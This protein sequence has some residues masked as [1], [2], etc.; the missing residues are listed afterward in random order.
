MAKFVR[1]AA[2]VGALSLAA[3]EIHQVHQA[4]AACTCMCRAASGIPE[5]VSVNTTGGCD[6][7]FTY[8]FNAHYATNGD[9]ACNTTGLPTYC[10]VY[11]NS[12]Y[13]DNM[14]EAEWHPLK[15]RVSPTSFT[16]YGAGHTQPITVDGG[17]HDEDENGLS[18]V[19]VYQVYYACPSIEPRV[20][21]LKDPDCP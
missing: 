1:L 3:F 19:T 16:I 18:A 9:P 8:T 11:P 14:E 17:L 20:P 21:V 5:S 12:S 10:C 4:L 2:A 13:S 15:H 6:K 7:G